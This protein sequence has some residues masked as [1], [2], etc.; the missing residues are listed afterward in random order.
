MN[1]LKKS[2]FKTKFSIE[3]IR[4]GTLLVF[5]TVQRFPLTLLILIVLAMIT[6][7]RIEVPYEE[8]KDIDEILNHTG[9]S[10]AQLKLI[11][12]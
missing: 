8:I 7:Y 2:I 11:A 4:N 10:L 6:I 1:G 9:L 3:N 5:N 12:P